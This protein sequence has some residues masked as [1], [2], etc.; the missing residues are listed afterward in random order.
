MAPFAGILEPAQL[1]EERERRRR[2]I[3]PVS[4]PVLGDLGWDVP[5]LALD[6]LPSHGEGLAAALAGEQ[7]EAEDGRGHRVLVV[8]ERP[9]GLNLRD[10]QVAVAA[11]FLSWL[12]D[13]C[14]GVVVHVAPGL[15]PVED[16]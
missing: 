14:R 2:K 9:E 3:Q 7:Q 16:L 6:I 11:S 5:P 4:E 15:R 13:I 10:A 1:L 12:L 8:P